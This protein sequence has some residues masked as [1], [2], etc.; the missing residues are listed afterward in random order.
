MALLG[1]VTGSGSHFTAV[2]GASVDGRIDGA[3]AAGFKNFAAVTSSNQL[4]LG[5]SIHITG[6]F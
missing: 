5:G 1:Q 6:A 2:A 3:V 4:Q